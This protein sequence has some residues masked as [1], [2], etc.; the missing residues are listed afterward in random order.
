M[1]ARIFVV[2]FERCTLPGSQVRNAFVNQLLAYSKLM[3]GSRR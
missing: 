2:M 1:M 3:S